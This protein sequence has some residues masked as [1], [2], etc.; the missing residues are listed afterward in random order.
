MLKILVHKPPKKKDVQQ[1]EIEKEIEEVVASTI[2]IPS[3][4]R[5][6]KTPQKISSCSLITDALVKKR[7]LRKMILPSKII[8]EEEDEEVE[9]SLVRR[10]KV[11]DARAQKDVK[12]VSLKGAQLIVFALLDQDEKQ[13][14]N[15]QLKEVVAEGEVLETD[16][17]QAVEVIARL[18]TVEGA[19]EAEASCVSEEVV[20]EAATN[21][22]FEVVSENKQATIDAMEIDIKGNNFNSIFE[23]YFDSSILNHIS[24][25][26]S[27]KPSPKH[28]SSPVQQLEHVMDSPNPTPII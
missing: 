22:I 7:K 16:E 12:G 18:K 5:N 19:S 9:V 2:L 8:E 11:A 27:P 25:T 23:Y 4:T 26:P 24:P 21:L 3:K 1:K 14:A 17:V 13:L 20:S 15:P 6:G 28:T 10:N